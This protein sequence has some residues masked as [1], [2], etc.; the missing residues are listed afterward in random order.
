M[1]IEQWLEQYGY[2]AVFFGIFVEGPIVLTMAGFLA[3]QGYLNFM[4]AFLTAFAATFLLVEISYLV[5]LTGGQYLLARRPSWREKL[6][7]FSALLYKY[8]VIFM[9]FFRF[10]Q[11]AQVIAS[12]AIGISRIR[13]GYFSAMNAAGAVLWT[14]VFMLIGYFFGHSFEMLIEDLK[15]YEK[16]LSLVLVA[17]ILIYYLARRLVWRRI[18]RTNETPR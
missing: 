7:R 17:L 3:H 13:P 6:R 18:S 4:A 15:H 8:R 1:N 9:L 14:A 5:G 16:P 11:G 12:I 10:I 2:W